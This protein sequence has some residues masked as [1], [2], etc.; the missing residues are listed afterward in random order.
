VCDPHPLEPLEVFR[1]VELRLPQAEDLATAPGQWLCART[2][3]SVRP[4]CSIVMRKGKR[5]S[6]VR[7]TTRWPPQAESSSI[8]RSLATAPQARAVHA[9]C[10]GEDHAAYR[11]YVKA[12]LT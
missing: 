9:P 5:R 4:S 2:A 3:S 12:Y 1:G 11:E 8:C 6:C 10:D 7:S